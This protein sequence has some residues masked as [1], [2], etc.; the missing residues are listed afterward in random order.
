[1]RKAQLTDDILGSIIRYK[2]T[3]EQPDEASREGMSYEACQLAS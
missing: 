3:G 1:M 2:E